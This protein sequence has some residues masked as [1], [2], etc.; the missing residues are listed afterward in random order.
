MKVEI[1]SDVI[2]PFCGIGNH[3]LDAAIA[4]FAHAADVEVVH[5]SFQ[6]DPSFPVGKTSPVREMLRAKYGMGEAQLQANWD[7]IEA[8][9]SADGLT[10]YKLDNL[11]GNTRM[12]HELLAFAGEKGLAAKAWKRLYRAYFGEGKSI[13]DVDSLVAL[14][15]E[16]G[17]EADELR[18]ALASGRYAAKVVADGEAARKLG[19]RGVPF[20]VIDGRVGV[21]GAQPLDVFRSALERA[22]SENPTP[23]PAVAGADTCGDDGCAVPGQSGG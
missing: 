18:D 10:P 6:L 11:T 1:W 17:L 5:R 8:Q 22:W 2:C 23:L 12:A 15:V 14:G 16:I 13:F 20:V 4:D 9:A 7:R 21:A 3:R 19:A